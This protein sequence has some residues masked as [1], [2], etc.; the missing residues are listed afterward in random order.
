MKLIN[1]GGATYQLFDLA[2][3]PQERHDL[4]TDKEKLGPVLER[5]QAVRARLQEIEVK[6]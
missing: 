2:N 5:M 6:P 1:S 4:A 3:D